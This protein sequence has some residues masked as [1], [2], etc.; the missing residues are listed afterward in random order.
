[1][2]VPWLLAQDD[3]GDVDD[4]DDADDVGADDDDDVGADDR[5]SL[6]A[7]AGCTVS[8]VLPLLLSS[9]SSPL[10]VLSKFS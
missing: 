8:T 5:S 3:D 1:M 9:M 6:G 10:L 7:L 4:D 2:A